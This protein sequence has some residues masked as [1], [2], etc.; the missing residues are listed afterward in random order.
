MVIQAYKCTY[1]LLL[2]QSDANTHTHTHWQQAI[3]TEAALPLIYYA[4]A[5][6]RIRNVNELVMGRT[7]QGIAEKTLP[8]IELLP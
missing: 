6:L 5:I 4:I 1:K 8:D 2:L 7:G 3:E